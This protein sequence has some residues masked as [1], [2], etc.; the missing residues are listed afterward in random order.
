MKIKVKTETFKTNTKFVTAVESHFI[1]KKRVDK[2]R[3]T[4]FLKAEPKKRTLTNIELLHMK[5]YRISY[6]SYVSY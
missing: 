1:N 6:K 5:Y 4:T 2:T 3:M